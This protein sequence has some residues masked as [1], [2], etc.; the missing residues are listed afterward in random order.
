M[1]VLI[2]DGAT[3]ALKKTLARFP[4]TALCGS[5]R[6]DGKLL[7]AGCASGLV[8]VFDL[9]SRAVL[10][11]FKLHKRAAHVSHFTRDRTHVLSA[12]DDATVRL[13]DLAHGNQ[14]SRFDGHQDYVRAAAGMSDV[15]WA[16]GSYDHTVKVWDVRVPQAVMTLEHGAPVEAVTAVGAAGHLLASAGGAA[17]VVWDLVGGGRT[18]SRLTNHQKTVTS[19]QSVAVA[20]ASGLVSNRLV[21]GALDGHV[22]VYDL[23]TFTTAYAFKY[24]AAV[25]TVAV[26]PGLGSMIVGLADRSMVVRRHK[27]ESRTLTAPG[28]L[29]QASYKS[30]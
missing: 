26:A 4:D 28:A 17:A 8:Q 13:W 1:Q 18:I 12:A 2:Y 11:Q 9:A 6:N 7:V 19:V 30:G 10:R 24:P 5:F 23:S 27:G 21:T 3:H 16:T 29:H 22:K 20:D 25:T 15:T 14:I